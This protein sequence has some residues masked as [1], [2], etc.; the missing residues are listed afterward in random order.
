MILTQCMHHNLR[1]ASGRG[2][3][4]RVMNLRVGVTLV[5]GLFTGQNVHRSRGR[6]QQLR[7][8][9]YLIMLSRLVI[10]L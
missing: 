8:G 5:I 7:F 3:G 10:D 2:A 9:I 1:Q 6:R 4:H